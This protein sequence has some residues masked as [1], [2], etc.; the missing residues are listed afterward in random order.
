[1][2]GAKCRDNSETHVEPAVPD[3]GD[4]DSDRSVH[5]K[6]ALVKRHDVTVAQLVPRHHVTLV[7]LGQLSLAFI[8]EWR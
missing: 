8:P 2:S 3:G 6:L 5:R 7:R 4:V 1:M